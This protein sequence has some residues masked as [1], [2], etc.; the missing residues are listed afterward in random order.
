[1]FKMEYIFHHI[2][3][4]TNDLDQT[5]LMLSLFGYSAEDIQY[6]SLQNVTVRFMRH[7][8]NPLI[9]LIFS[10]G[11]NSPIQNIIRKNGTCAY[12]LCYAVD[13]I[14]EAVSIMRRDGYIP[15]GE[16]RKSVI[17]GRDVIFLYHP[18]NCL[19]ELLDGKK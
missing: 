4:A 3:I 2:G 5:T 8:R 7:E 15:T 6:D 14:D 16:K 17:D 1:M 10:G 12:H 13:D 18:H 11:D 19:I 9:E